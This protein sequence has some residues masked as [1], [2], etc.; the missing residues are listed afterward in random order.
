MVEHHSPS[1]VDDIA[2]RMTGGNSPAGFRAAVMDRLTPQRTSRW[3]A[4]WLRWSMAA[5][6]IVAAFVVWSVAKQSEAPAPVVQ[7]VAHQ[8]SP[9]VEAVSNVAATDVAPRRLARKR[10]E[11]ISEPGLPLLD[12]PE[13]LVVDEIQPPRLNITQL[14]L[15]PLATEPIRATLPDGGGS[16]Q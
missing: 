6:A 12:A 3:S 10:P 13:A 2:A 14:T 16:Q 9:S 5:A 8:D 7:T 15:E 1:L 4:L 11:P